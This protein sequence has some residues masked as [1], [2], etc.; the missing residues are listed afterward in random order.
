M[1]YCLLNLEALASN[2]RRISCVMGGFDRDTYCYPL[3][4]YDNDIVS[5]GCRFSSPVGLSNS[6]TIRPQ[7]SIFSIAKLIVTTQPPFKADKY[8]HYLLA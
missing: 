6:L 1:A 8:R 2:D 3:P 5:R 7:S 4:E